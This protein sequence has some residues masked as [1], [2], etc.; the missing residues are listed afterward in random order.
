MVFRVKTT[1]SAILLTLI[2]ATAASSEQ[3]YVSLKGNFYIS[4]PDDWAQ[5]DYWLVDEYLLR[6]ADT[7]DSA[8]FAYEAVLA[9]KDV[10]HFF[11][12]EYLILTVDTVGKLKDWQIDSILIDLVGT[13]EEP[14]RYRTLSDF[15][16]DPKVNIPIYDTLAQMVALLDEIPGEVV[17]KSLSVMRFYDKGIA[18]FYFY[19]PDT[20][21]ESSKLRFAQILAS[22]S[23][24]VETALPKEKLKVADLKETAQQKDGKSTKTYLFYGVALVL[25]LLIVIRRL[26]RR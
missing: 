6:T 10:P 20:V 8:L 26:K 21:F 17:R 12:G 1:C 22:F 9:Q 24:D 13:I 11:S 15:L 7:L 18:T 14:V 19:A 4:Y 2:L 16:A 3:H 5:V 23:T 25:I